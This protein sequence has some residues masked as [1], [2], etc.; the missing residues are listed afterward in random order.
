MG[1]NPSRSTNATAGGSGVPGRHVRSAGNGVSPRSYEE[2]PL[3]GG[4]ALPKKARFSMESG[5]KGLS[6]AACS[7]VLVIIVAIVVFL[8]SKAAP[9]LKADKTN[10]LT[11]KQWFPNDAAP[12]FGI[13]SLAFGPVLTAVAREQRGRPGESAARGVAE[14]GRSHQREAG[15]QIEQDAPEHARRSDQ[16]C[17]AEETGR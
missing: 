3:G 6:L 4:G 7:M 2:P 16:C 5:F 14:H 8:I 11:D 12:H 15:Q 17:S 10:F 13:A 1:D 9:A